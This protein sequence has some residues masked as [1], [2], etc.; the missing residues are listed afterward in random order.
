MSDVSREEILMILKTAESMKFVMKQ[1]NKKAPHLQGKTVILLFYEQSIRASLSY[2]MAA[3]YLSAHVADMSFDAE[4]VGDLSEMGQIIDQMGGDFIIIRHTMS[5]SAKWLAQQVKARVINAGDG[6]NE[7]PSQSLLD[8]MTIKTLKGGFEGLKITFVGDVLHS[9]VTR[10]N[11]WALMKLG[12]DLTLAGPPT[13]VPDEWSS[14]GIKILY[15]AAEA[16]SGAD[17]I[18]ALRMR[19]E[20]EYGSLLSSYNEYK[21]FFEVDENILRYAKKDAIVIHPGPINRGIEV[22]AHVAESN[23]CIVDDLIANG[24]AVRMALFYLLT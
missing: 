12:A 22:S 5:G 8:L 24:V 23:Q 4:R 1:K 14:Y 16:V 19:G 2:Q 9:R 21:S 3:A 15:D 11:I 18:M 13:L 7:N 17:V 20:H 10:S 6:F